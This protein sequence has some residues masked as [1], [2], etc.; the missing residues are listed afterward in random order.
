MMTSLVLVHGAWHD[1]SAFKKSTEYLIAQ[2]ASI[3]TPTV[4]GNGPGDPKN[5][6]LAEAI[7]S[8]E[9]YIIK[10]DLRDIVLCGHSYGGMIITGV[11]DRLKE[12]LKRLIYWNAF[13]PKHGES[14]E[15]MLTPAFLELL[16]ALTKPD[17]SFMLPFDIWRE[18]FINDASLEI[19]LKTYAQLNP[20]PRKTFSD[21]IQLKTN[22]DQLDIG[23]SFINCMDDTAL[24]QSEG[25]HPRLSEKLGVFR[26]IQVRGSHELCFTNPKSLSQAI[27]EAARD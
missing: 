23:K 14:L 22:P 15:D 5:I 17:G 20:H 21:P 16:D 8:I 25:W 1:S 12:R 13:V 9:N 3:H 19:A 10:H 18:S 6:G 4:F 24:P 26:L 11:A 27:L 2:G 7:S